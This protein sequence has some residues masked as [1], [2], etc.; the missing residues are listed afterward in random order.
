MLHLWH[1]SVQTSG[2]PLHMRHVSL[3][4]LALLDSLSTVLH[5][6]DLSCLVT[7]KTPENQLSTQF[8]CS[9]GVRLK[10]HVATVWLI[11]YSHD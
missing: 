10:Y 11:L 4:L 2:Y 7:F 9:L 3:S 6:S 8:P 5:K 1:I